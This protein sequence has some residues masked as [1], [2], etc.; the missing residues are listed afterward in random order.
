VLPG[1]FDHR[2]LLHGTDRVR[3]P[4]L[5]RDATRSSL[6]VTMQDGRW[7]AY[8]FGD[9]ALVRA[10]AS[11]RAEAAA[12]EGARPEE[13]AEVWMPALN[14]VFIGRQRDG[15]LFLTPVT[16]D[17][18]FGFTRGETLPGREALRQSVRLNRLFACTHWVTFVPRNSITICPLAAQHHMG[19]CCDRIGTTKALWAAGL[20]AQLAMNRT[21]QRTRPDPRY[22]ATPSHEAPTVGLV[23]SNLRT[24]GR[25]CA[26]SGRPRH[27]F[28]AGVES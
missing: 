2:P 1:G 14:V 9:A 4:V 16:D 15:E 12:R 11:V 17:A 22:R 8:A 23:F 10:L 5:A 18:R 21:P 28:R 27:R 24:G 13:Y 7:T 26:S 20:H 25:R 3:F 19:V 6:T